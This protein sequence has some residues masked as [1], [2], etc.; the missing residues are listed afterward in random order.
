MRSS[1]DDQFPQLVLQSS[2]DQRIVFQ[3]RDAAHDLVQTD[4][5]FTDIELFQISLF[6]FP[7]KL[8]ESL[9]CDWNGAC[10][11]ENQGVEFAS[12]G[13]ER[14]GGPA[15]CGTEAVHELTRMPSRSR[16]ACN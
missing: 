15:R 12:I 4:P 5:R 9:R 7:L 13:P 1:A 8:T 16:N 3:N 10:N 6:I 14:R 2:T 11:Q